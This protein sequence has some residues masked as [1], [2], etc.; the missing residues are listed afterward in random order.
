MDT[1]HLTSPEFW[2]SDACHVMVNRRD[3]VAVEQFV[4]L[5]QWCADNARLRGHLLFATSGSTGGGTWVALSRQALLASA[6]AVN[7]HLG[8][9]EDDHWLLALPTF[10][11]GGMGII[12]R[13][14][15]A[16]CGL[17]VYDDV[18]DAKKFHR[19][20]SQNVTL[21]S[22][23]PTQLADIVSVGLK[24]PEPLRAVLVGG[25]ALPDAVYDQAAE[26]GWPVLETYGM[27][28]AASQVATASV[29][30]RTLRILPCWQTRTEPDGRLSIKG[31]PLLTA[32]VKLTDGRVVSENPLAERWFTTSDRAEIA[33]NVLVFQGRSDRCVKVLG[34]LVDLDNVEKRLR[35]MLE[36]GEVAVVTLPDA[37]KGSALVACL[38]SLSD[39]AA[40]QR[41]VDDY[42]LTCSPVARVN[43]VSFLGAFP[44]S[45]L[46]KIRYAELQQRVS[47]SR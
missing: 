42:N 24:S 28:E 22:L 6:Q 20:L 15:L 34:E 11:V 37:R 45:S 44:R 32:Y 14:R 41:V 30:D 40:A 31:E 27:T 12:A 29:G 5:R 3:P 7:E 33:G 18:W 19:A 39:P 13:A 36:G 16:S 46:G 9:T 23:V 21:T 2:E 4:L 35:D 10:H 17:S 47:S 26:L 8:V 38:E 1:A 43:S 25:G